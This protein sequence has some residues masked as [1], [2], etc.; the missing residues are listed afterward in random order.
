MERHP[1]DDRADLLRRLSAD[2][3]ACEIGIDAERLADRRERKDLA[4]RHI[5]RVEDVAISVGFLPRDL[6]SNGG[7]LDVLR[8]HDIIL[9]LYESDGGHQFAD[10]LR[11]EFCSAEDLLK[12][13]RMISEPMLSDCVAPQSMIYGTFFIRAVSPAFT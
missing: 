12:E 11:G 6:R 10:R 8:S 3:L 5:F 4:R 7:T 9:D 1:L 13:R 2:P